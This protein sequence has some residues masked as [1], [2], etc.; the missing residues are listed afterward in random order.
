MRR[1]CPPARSAGNGRT[2]ASQRPQVR[3]PRPRRAALASARP[4]NR[5]TTGEAPRLR[6]NA[7]DQRLP[8]PRGLPTCHPPLPMTSEMLYRFI[9]PYSV[10]KSCGASV[11][12]AAISDAFPNGQSVREWVTESLLPSQQIPFHVPPALEARLR[13]THSDSRLSRCRHR[14]RSCHEAQLFPEP[15]LLHFLFSLPSFP[16]SVKGDVV[17][18]TLLRAPCLPK[19][20]RKDV[21]R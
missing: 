13:H 20:T 9:S 11:A 1:G 5:S 21:G 3:P 4:G 16:R 10:K 6:A 12:A 15:K 18:T 19:R 14:S 7:A 2:S 17:I 8:G